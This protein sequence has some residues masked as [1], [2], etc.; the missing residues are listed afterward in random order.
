MGQTNGH[1]YKLYVGT[2]DGVCTL[3]SSGGG[4]TWQQGNVTPLPHAAAR[5]TASASDPQRA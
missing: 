2:H 4:G 1:D 5:L 3:T